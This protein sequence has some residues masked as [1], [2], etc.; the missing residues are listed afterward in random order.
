MVAMRCQDIRINPTT[1][2]TYPAYAQLLRCFKRRDPS[3][4]M[5]SP[6]LLGHLRRA[7]A[8]VVGS[9]LTPLARWA[10]I[11][12]FLGLRSCEFLLSYY[13]AARPSPDGLPRG[14][15]ASDITFIAT[16]GSTFAFDAVFLE[17]TIS[18]VRVRFRFQKNGD[19]NV[20]RDMRKSG[21]ALFCP[22]L[23]MLQNRAHFLSFPARAR[24]SA[25]AVGTD[26]SHITTMAMSTFI[27]STVRLVTPDISENDLALFT[28]HSFRVGALHHLLLSR[29]SV[30]LAVDYLRWRSAAYML[31]VR[32][33]QVNFAQHTAAVVADFNADAN[34]DSDTD[35]A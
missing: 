20:S 32:S 28:P 9:A 34:Y 35:D 5:R 33:S 11:A 17:S 31:Y 27:K 23:I 19:N 13:S 12:I 22:V 15:L 30:D 3:R 2:L 29:V 14:L 10:A 7:Y 18:I 16:D 21:D 1:G 6:F 25:F 4:A 24:N 26:G 8:R